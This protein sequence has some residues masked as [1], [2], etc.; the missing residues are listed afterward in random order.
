M[1]GL[2]MQMGYDVDKVISVPKTSLTRYIHIT[3]VCSDSS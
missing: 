1:G 2:L 3:R